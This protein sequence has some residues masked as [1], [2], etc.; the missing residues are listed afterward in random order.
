V[1]TATQGTTVTGS[2]IWKKYE[3]GP[4][5]PDVTNVTLKIVKTDATVLRAKS[6]V[7]VLNPAPGVFSYSYAVAADLEAGSDYLWVWEAEDDEGDLVPTIEEM[8]VVGAT[9]EQDL[10]VTLEKANLW[11]GLDF[12]VSELYQAQ[13]VVEAYANFGFEESDIIIRDRDKANLAKATAYQALFMRYNP[14]LFANK[15]LSQLTQNSMTAN[16]TSQAAI[17]L[18]PV[19][20]RCIQNL[21]WRQISSL[22]FEKLRGKDS[23]YGERGFTNEASDEY[24]RPWR[25]LPTP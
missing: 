8:T 14:G 25:P 22:P 2:V 18:S 5:N 10:W 15:S 13:A 6:S 24:G 16:F 17:I 9:T 11:T 1:I 19:S 23:L 7:G 3:G 21:T 12:E 4:V 20:L